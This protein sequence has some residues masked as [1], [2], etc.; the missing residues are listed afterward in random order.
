MPA[1][2]RRSHGRSILDW[3][4][5]ARKQVRKYRPHVT[6]VFIGA[7]DTEPL[8]SSGGPQVACCHRAWIDAYADRVESMMR[9]YM[10]G[11]RRDVY[12]LTLPAP[13]QR[14]PPPAVP[15]D[16]L[17]DRAGRAQGRPEGACGRHRARAVAAQP[18][19]AQAP[20]PREASCRARRR[21]RSP[22]DGRLAHGARPGR[23]Q[24]AARR[25]ARPPAPPR[26]RR[27]QHSP[28]RAR[29]ALS[30]SP[31]RTRS[32]SGRA[33]QPI[34]SRWRRAAASTSS[35]TERCRFRPARDAWPSGRGRCGARCRGRWATAACSW[36]PP[37]G[38]T[39]SGSGA[40]PAG[41][42]PKHAAAVGTT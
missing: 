33:A 37:A 21:R 40:S 30:T 23:A 9:T 25:R 26:A 19:P 11:Q 29:C 8:S 5:H 41:R 14:E 7:G 36:M 3:V 35:P 39:T 15:R 31:P 10:R 24:D 32:R 6:V 16:Q 27:R 4:K 20:L 42:W 34:G 18:I 1:P 13:R 17:R 12:W 28:T 38:M 22:D 2:P